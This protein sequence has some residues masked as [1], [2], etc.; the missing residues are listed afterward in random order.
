MAPDYFT[1][2][3]RRVISAAIVAD[4][5]HVN[6][7]TEDKEHGQTPNHKSTHFM[8]R[9]YSG[10]KGVDIQADGLKAATLNSASSWHVCSA[11]AMT[12]GFALL[13]INPRSP[14]MWP[15]EERIVRTAFATLVLLSVM[16][17]VAG[18]FIGAFFVHDASMVPANL[19]GDFHHAMP[20]G[21]STT[22]P[23]KWSYFSLTS[24]SLSTVPLCWLLYG[25]IVGVLAFTVHA[26]MLAALEV[27]H[28]E[29]LAMW[30]RIEERAGCNAGDLQLHGWVNMSI[31]DRLV[32]VLRASLLLAEDQQLL[33][34]VNVIAR[35]FRP[36]KENWRKLNDAY[37]SGSLDEQTEA[38]AKR[39]T[40]RMC[41]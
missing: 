9:Q 30:R 28:M 15:A 32:T 4:A 13:G 16:A 23:L 25:E 40:E 14:S 41:V 22:T 6:P 1:T 7:L 10:Y 35:L 29:R 2:S 34:L 36:Q 31:I 18:V 11:L 27:V 33:L 20:Q 17:A 3:K 38:G 37:A 5:T 24:L 26:L 39:C 19:Y 21:W 8:W 12:A